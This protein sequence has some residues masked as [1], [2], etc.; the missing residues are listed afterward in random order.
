VAGGIDQLVPVGQDVQALSKLL[1]A[2]QAL[3][4]PVLLSQQAVD[5]LAK[6]GEGLAVHEHVQIKLAGQTQQIYR[7][8]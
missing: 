6:Q 1:K 3:R 2:G 7:A 4:W 8:A 5:A